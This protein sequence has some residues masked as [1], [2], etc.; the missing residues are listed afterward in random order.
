[1]MDAA[2]SMPVASAL[3]KKRRKGKD[4]SPRGKVRRTLLEE[5]RKEKGSGAERIRKEEEDL[6][7]GGR[8]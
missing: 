6:N 2:I 1:M 5:E 4:K 7:G 8:E 3:M